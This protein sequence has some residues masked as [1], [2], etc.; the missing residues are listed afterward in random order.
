MPSLWLEMASL[1]CSSRKNA[2][3]SSVRAASALILLRIEMT[4]SLIEG[5][6]AMAS[7]MSEEEKPASEGDLTVAY[8]LE[9]CCNV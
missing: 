2:Y 9:I 6:A 3:L 5:R 1:S 4:I 8:S 7:L